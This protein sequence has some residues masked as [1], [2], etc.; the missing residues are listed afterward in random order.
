MSNKQ[1]IHIP[2]RTQPSRNRSRL[3]IGLAL[4]ASAAACGAEAPEGPTVGSTIDEIIGGFPATSAKLN[5]IGAIGTPDGNGGF[6]PTC[7]GTLITPTVVLTAKH[8]LNAVDPTQLV[9]LIGPNAFAPIRIVSVRGAAVE[10]TL[11]GGVIGFGSDIGVLHLA[12]AVTN[13]PLLPVAELTA[14]VIGSRLVA[15]GYGVQNTDLTFGTRRSGSMTVRATAGSVFAAIFGSFDSF[16]QNGAA[17]LFPELDP[18]DPAQLAL[19]QQQFD[20]TRLLDGIEAF[21]GGV[22][23]DAQACTGDGGGPLTARVGTQTTVLAVSSW[24]FGSNATCTLDGSAFAS[25]NPVSLDFI[26]Y[27]TH[28]PLVPRAGTCEGLAVALRCANV[29]EGG[30]REL[31]TDCGELGQICGVDDNGELGCI[32]DPCEGL[33][34]EGVCNGEIVTRCSTPDEGVRRVVTTDCAAQ[35]QECTLDSGTAACVTP[36]SVCAHDRCEIG[37]ALDANCDTCVGQICAA[38][39][40]CCNTFWDS[41]CVAEVS[42]VCG[43]SCGQAAE[44][45]PQPRP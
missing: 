23:G 40:F 21:A 20:E 36:M 29:N 27:E 5:A 15:L 37:A 2:R 39:S 8:C 24:G 33:P 7:T 9:F 11:S 34:P 45:G 16:L 41:L 13:V 3:V 25:M 30:R 44:L 18:G 32:D 28:C 31:R 43:L 42:S 38:D 4:A 14:S 1:V 12:E 19:L 22:G 10:P 17:R 35:G 26:D 6:T